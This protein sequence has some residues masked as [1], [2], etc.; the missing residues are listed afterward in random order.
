MLANDTE[1]RTIGARA[2][3]VAMRDASAGLRTAR[4]VCDLLERS[5]G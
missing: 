4:I 5:D 2:R 3:Q 1:R